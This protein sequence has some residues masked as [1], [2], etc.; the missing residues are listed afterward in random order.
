MEDVV[1]VIMEQLATVGRAVHVVLQAG[2]V[3]ALMHTAE[4]EINRFTMQ[5]MTVHQGPVVALE[6]ITVHPAQVVALEELV[7]L[8]QREVVALFQQDL[9]APV[10]HRA[11]ALPY[12][13]DVYFQV[14]Q[15]VVLLWR[16]TRTG[17]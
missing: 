13:H 15:I 16:P 9:V 6:E 7:P 3:E 17:V 14:V 5:E 11:V 12:P 1:L 4:Q 8:V 2:G 10:Q